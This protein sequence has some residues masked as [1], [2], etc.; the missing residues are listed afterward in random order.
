MA[1]HH[2]HH[3]SHAHENGA[4]SE[5][6]VFLAMVLTGGFML[7]EVAG[8]IVSGSLALL[9]DAGHMLTDFASL[10]LAWFG[11]R[12]A[13]RPADT[14]RSYG[15]HRMEVLAAFVNGMALVA[16]VGWIFYEAVHRLLDPPVI[17]GG[18][19]LAVASVGLVVNVVAFWLLHRG[20]R[21]NL[22]VRGAAAH[23]L[24]D[25]L[26]S[27]A[28]IA[29]AVVILATDWTPIDPLLSVLVGLLVLRSAWGIITD[30][31][32]ILLEGTPPDMAVEELT[33]GLEAAVPEVEDVHHVHLWCLTPRHTLMTLHVSVGEGADRDRVLARVAGFLHEHWGIEHATIQVERSGCVDAPPQPE[34][35]PR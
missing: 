26:G 13:R 8:G 19:M 17:L 10:A 30:S 14:V 35:K 6:R 28:A 4:D 12:L 29:A 7:V 11:F 1:S 34:G 22:N 32:H 33:A 5:R 20:D 21:D 31:G 2:H 9:A 18:T 16:V 24:G 15:Y 23:V 3:H 25:L 27:V